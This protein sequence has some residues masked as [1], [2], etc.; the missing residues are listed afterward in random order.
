MH[1]ERASAAVGEEVWE[2]SWHWDKTG[3][4]GSSLPLSKFAQ[5]TSPHKNL[6]SLRCFLQRNESKVNYR[7]W[8]CFA[9]V[10]WTLMESLLTRNS[11]TLTHC[12]RLMEF[13]FFF[14][15]SLVAHFLVR[16]SYTWDNRCQETRCAGCSCWAATMCHCPLSS[17]PLGTQLS[18]YSLSVPLWLSPFGRA[19]HTQGATQSLAGVRMYSSTAR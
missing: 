6:Q 5:H 18:F 3:S 14:T 9:E 16:K 19:G 12:Y 10:S 8:L 7:I 15:L 2:E 1:G 11:Y 17:G 13:A 4:S